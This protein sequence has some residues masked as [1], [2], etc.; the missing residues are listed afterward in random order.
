LLGALVVPIV[1]A[2]GSGAAEPL[3]IERLAQ[4]TFSG[5]DLD[6]TRRFYGDVL[7]FEEVRQAKDASG[8]LH[9]LVFKV[10]DDQFLAF[11]A[12]AGSFR[13]VGISLLTPEIGRARAWVAEHR[14]APSEVRTQDD[15]NPHFALTDP[16]GTTVDF[17]EYRLGSWQAEL[18]GKALGA[19]RISDHLQHAG[20]V[21]ASEPAAMGFYR[22]K[23]GFWEKNRGGPMPGD[24][25]WIIMLMPVT[26]GDFIEFMVY[27][28]DPPER[29]Q[30]I[31]F[32]VPDIDR[33]HRELIDAG[34]QQKFKPFV[35]NTGLHLMNV[36]DPNGL[37]VEFWEIR[38][39]RQG[40]NP[41]G[42][43]R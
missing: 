40:G 2:P 4:V 6:K 9:G 23:L 30:H 20:L 3:P 21:V 15:G 10:N 37:R 18:R 36:R 14:L 7:G 11:S 29:R 22:E 39:D 13:L 32:A 19:R 1:G 24:V 41:A 35:T 17:V 28:Q 31:C 27:A 34:V 38:P 33:T 43:R 16:D 26:T 8:Q 25:R 12:G 42:D 5:A